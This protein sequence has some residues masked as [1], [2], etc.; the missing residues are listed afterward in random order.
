MQSTKG[1][2]WRRWDLHVH[3]A[4]SYDSGYCAQDADEMLC[5]VLRTNEISAVAITDHFKIDSKRIANLRNLAPDI[6]FFPGVE[7]RTDKGAR[8]LHVI[9]IFSEQDNLDT[10]SADFEVI[11]LRQKA[12]SQQSNDT[13]YWTF[14]DIVTFSRDHGG[15]ISIHA[16]GKSNGIDKEIT[17]ALPVNEAIKSDIASNIDFF[18]VG[19]ISDIAAYYEHVFKDVEE[20]PIIL[21]SDCHD[22]RRYAPKENLWIKANLTFEGLKQCVFQPKERVY[23][24]VIPPALDRAMK[25]KKS[26]INGLS[27]HQK[28]TPINTNTNWFDFDLSLNTGLVSIIGNK[29]SGKSALADIIGHLCKCRTMP[30][31][32]F[33]N[34]SRFRKMPKNYADDYA[35]TIKWDDQH[36]ESIPLSTRNY[37]TTIEDAQYLPQQYIE[38][39]CNDIDNKFQSEIDKVIFSYVDPTERGNSKDLNELVSHKSNAIEINVEKLKD[40]MER[41]NDAIIKLE[42][43]KTAQY[44]THIADSLRKMRETLERHG[45]VRPEEVKEPDKRDGDAAY[46]EKLHEI[47]ACVDVMEKLIAQHREELTLVNIALDDSSQ[48]ISKLEILEKNVDEVDKSIAEYLTKYPLENAEGISLMTPKDYI[49]KHIATM[50]DRKALIQS[51]LNGTEPEDGLMKKLQR[52]RDKK[53]LLIS[54]ADGEEKQYQKYLLDL[55]GWEKEKTEIIGGSK[56]ENSLTYFEC[57]LDY[58]EKQL[59]SDYTSLKIQRDNKIRDLFSKKS[60][61]VAVYQKIYEPIENEIGTLLGELEDT[62]EFAAE[63]QL[64]DYNLTEKLLAQIN[65]RYAGVFKGKAE[66]HN[67]MSQLIR[68]TEFHNAESILD[69][70][71]EV[72]IV[73]DED[74]DGASKKISDKQVLY[75]ALHNLDYIGVSFKLKMGGRSLE[76]L[77]PGE[78]GI[79]LLIFYLALSQNDFPI[80]ID[81]P[82]DNLDNQSVY[83]KL[84]PCICAAKRK[85]QV[86]IVT[87]NPNIAI[88]CDAE[89]I[90]YSHMD[91]TSYKISYSSGAIEDPAIKKHVIDVLEGT[92]PAFDLRNKKYT[93]NQ[94]KK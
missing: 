67:K 44:K 60:E 31:A 75:A 16:G 78:R 77:S 15:L 57:E 81:Q 20:K 36:S 82:E 71:H 70:I 94:A 74:I 5:Q 24:G 86:I 28:E 45:N 22:P 56:T 72:L 43:K 8:N 92:M 18:E 90:I 10:L 49:L 63:I 35:A 83:S 80:I 19:K 4:S 21:C 76:E 59:E 42:E 64:S 58:L 14:E 30:S 93:A 11:M 3:T 46:Q 9:L 32:S 91:K 37:N 66:A 79:V 54:T 26:T 27:V 88:A 33:L 51:A 39:V 62:I 12:K 65:Q 84:V 29:G 6:V 47:N 85:R 89:Q 34:E 38:E 69:F 52:E 7:L 50:N 17:N 25:N 68:K 48:L 2:E 87:H 40:D 73:V 41:I 55:E 1:S 53:T 61:L 13:I 23:V